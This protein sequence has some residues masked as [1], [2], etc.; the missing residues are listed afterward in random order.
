MR[1]WA[2]TQW[3]ELRKGYKSALL[4]FIVA[5]GMAY[6]KDL[7]ERTHIIVTLPERTEAKLNSMATRINYIAGKVAEIDNRQSITDAYLR[8]GR[9]S[10]LHARALYDMQLHS[11]ADDIA[12]IKRD[13]A[14]IRDHIIRSHVLAAPID[15]TRH[16]AQ[17]HYATSKLAY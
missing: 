17:T 14:Q 7:V 10:A 16:V 5:S 9:D 2:Q 4:A 13:L 8:A 12:E 3:L 15:N 6:T 11:H 1:Q